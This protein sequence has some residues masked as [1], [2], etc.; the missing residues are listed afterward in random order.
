MLA[1]E[2][3]PPLVFHSLQLALNCD[4]FQKIA[5]PQ[6]LDFVFLELLKRRWQADR[7]LV[8]KLYVIAFLVLKRKV[9][10]ACRLITRPIW[11]NWI[12]QITVLLFPAELLDRLKH[13]SLA[14]RLRICGY[15]VL[16]W[17]ALLTLSTRC[18]SVLFRGH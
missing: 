14:R 2:K 4:F 16:G 3:R 18:L 6:P 9:M 13:G 15:E 11:K 8:L 7:R 5:W 17:L 1:L 10:F 12:R